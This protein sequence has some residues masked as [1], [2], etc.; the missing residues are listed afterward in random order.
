MRKKKMLRDALVPVTIFCT[1]I[2]HSAAL[3]A[4]LKCSTHEDLADMC[5][6]TR[7][8]LQVTNG[9]P[10]LR[11]WKVGTNRILGI[12]GGEQSPIAPEE[13]LEYLR[14]GVYIFGDFLVCPFEKDKPGWMQP[15]CI[16]SAKNI[17]IEDYR[18]DSAAPKT[19]FLEG[20]FGL[21]QD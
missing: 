19:K 16:E 21:S 15:V 7:G 12:S 9:T 17:R 8:R 13:L 18:G 1:V 14:F 6:Q 5:Y 4:E 3:G 20:P 10:G 11:I 2:V